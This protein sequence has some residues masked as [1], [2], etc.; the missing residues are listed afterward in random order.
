MRTAITVFLVGLAVLLWGVLT[1][2]QHLLACFFGGMLVG[3]SLSY[4]INNL[5]KE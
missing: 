4:I 3:G 2:G 1:P 5:R